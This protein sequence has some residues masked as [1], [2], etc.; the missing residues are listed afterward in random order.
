M[1]I[2]HDFQ[3]SASKVWEAALAEFGRE[4]KIDVGY[5]TGEQVRYE[6]SLAACLR[7][8]H[9][10]ALFKVRVPYLKKYDFLQ[11]FAEPLDDLKAAGEVAGDRLKVMSGDGKVVGLPYYVESIGI[12]Y[13]KKIMDRYFALEDRKQGIHSM[14]EVKSSQELIALADDIYVHREALQID[15]AF[16]TCS[17]APNS[18][19]QWKSYMLS[20]PVFY[21]SRDNKDPKVL[22]FTFQYAEQAKALYDMFF[23]DC[24]GR[25][26]DFGAVDMAA[27]EDMFMQGRAAM[28]LHLNSF[29][30]IYMRKKKKA[31]AELPERMPKEDELDMIPLYFGV[32]DERQNCIN[33]MVWVLCVNKK[34]SCEEKCCAKE[35]IDWYATSE[36]ARPYVKKM[37]Y[38]LPYRQVQRDDTDLHTINESV[39]N[40]LSNPRLEAIDFAH[41]MVPMIPSFRSGYAAGLLKYAKGE[42][43]F[44]DVVSQFVGQWEMAYDAAEDRLRKLFM[45]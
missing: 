38:M 45:D 35:F 33:G 17:F 21:E 37:G 16:P 19:D 28:I 10:P 5:T 29:R 42:I 36:A 9:P 25:P 34:A 40:Y 20:L 4:K 44:E 41:T 6:E 31:G 18:E 2:F 11:E 39:W 15:G 22:C 1:L 23:R 27:Q 43:A 13:N 7:S 26:E 12:V 32:E 8:E 14:K 3:S 24:A 30:E